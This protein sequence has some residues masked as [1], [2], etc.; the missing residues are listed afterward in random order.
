MY[1]AYNAPFIQDVCSICASPMHAFVDYPCVGKSDY[2][3]EQI[4]ATQG[5]PPSNNPYSNTYNHGWRNHPNFLSK[6]P[7]VKNP[8]A[9]CSRP[10]PHGFQN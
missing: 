8:Q 2:V 4:N 5:F 1:K 10:T 7:N 6:S 3:T 9:H